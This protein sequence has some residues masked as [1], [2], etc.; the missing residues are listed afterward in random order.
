[1]ILAPLTTRFQMADDD[2][3]AVQDPD[4]P[5]TLDAGAIYKYVSSHLHGFVPVFYNEEY[6]RAVLAYVRTRG[7]T[8]FLWGCESYTLGFAA[9]AGSGET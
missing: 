2:N 4:F 3:D 9:T 5:A 8:V 7:T 1:M 6:I